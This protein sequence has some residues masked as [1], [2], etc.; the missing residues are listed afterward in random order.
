MP[1][2]QAGTDTDLTYS[3]VSQSGDGMV[4]ASIVAGELVL[5]FVSPLS[6]GT[7]TIVVQAEDSVGNQVVDT[8]QV[9]SAE[10]IVTYQGWRESQFDGADLLDDAISGPS[11]DPN[12]DGITNFNLFV[13]GLSTSGDQSQK[14]AAP[15]LDLGAANSVL[16]I[17]VI[18]GLSGVEFI[19]EESTDLDDWMT[20]A[21][22]SAT[23]QEG[24]ERDV[25]SFTVSET[26]ATKSNVFYRVR[27]NQVTP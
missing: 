1:A 13:L 21:G 5:D 8:F 14:V 24:V 10:K 9:V 2:G 6:N 20:V 12:N 22:V 15:S 18:A 16:E 19:L 27:F 17:D 25:I 11:A 23:I 4:T 26:P 7:D 3:I